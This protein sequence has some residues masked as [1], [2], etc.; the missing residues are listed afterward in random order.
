MKT[1]KLY[2]PPLLWRELVPIFG[3]SGVRLIITIC[4]L[5]FTAIT[6]QAQE[7]KLSYAAIENT[8]TKIPKEIW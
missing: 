1:I 7:L 3:R 8:V 4:L 5:L 2:T 6:L